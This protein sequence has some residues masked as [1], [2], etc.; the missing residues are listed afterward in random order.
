VADVIT[1]YN[2]DPG[3]IRTKARELENNNEFS[4]AKAYYEKYLEFDRTNSTIRSRID[5]LE[6]RLTQGSIRIRT[7]VS[8][9]VIS[10]DGRE[11]GRGEILLDQISVGNHQVRVAHDRYQTE[12]RQVSVGAG[13]DGSNPVAIQL[14]LKPHFQY[15]NAIKS[16]SGRTRDRNVQSLINATPEGCEECVETLLDQLQNNKNESLRRAILDKF[17]TVV[18]ESDTATVNIL[19][20]ITQDTAY[21]ENTRK[22]AAEALNKITRNKY[23]ASDYKKDKKKDIIIVPPP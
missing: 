13:D 18:A 19:K 9:A 20:G 8:D 16:S 1:R 5:S 10:F 4:L 2:G 15:I 12:T 7:N 23:A 21:S 3:V 22:K 17:A 6:A 14:K 11:V